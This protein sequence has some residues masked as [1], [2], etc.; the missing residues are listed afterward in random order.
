MNLSVKTKICR[1]NFFVFLDKVK[2]SLLE[3]KNHVPKLTSEFLKLI[4]SLQNTEWKWENIYK[5]YT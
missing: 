4:W 5:T 3:N 1:W 2:I